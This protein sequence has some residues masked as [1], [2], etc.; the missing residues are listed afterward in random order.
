MASIRGECQVDPSARIS[1]KHEKEKESVSTVEEPSSIDEDQVMELYREQ[2]RLY[3]RYVSL[4]RGDLLAKDSD[5]PT[6][7]EVK[8]AKESW[9]EA[10]SAM[11]ATG[12]SQQDL[13]LLI[14]KN[15]D[16]LSDIRRVIKR[17]S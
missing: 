11:K 17:S 2:H 13:R 16:S 4:K 1:E 6:E 5:R 15:T 14:V 7:V 3:C 12:I 10:Y 9:L 8:M